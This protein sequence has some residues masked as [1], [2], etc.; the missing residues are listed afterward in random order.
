MATV[1]NINVW[2][3]LIIKSYF[4]KNLYYD[5]INAF[6]NEKSLSKHFKFNF[7]FLRTN[8]IIIH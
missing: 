7:N 4:T 1:G 2:I 6:S 5:D 3:V 8:F